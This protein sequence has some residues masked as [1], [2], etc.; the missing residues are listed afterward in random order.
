M[1][2]EASLANVGYLHGNCNVLILELYVAKIVL[3][4]QSTNHGDE[5]WPDKLD[6]T[7]VRPNKVGL[8]SPWTHGGSNQLL[9]GGK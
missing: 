1:E 3:L 7:I 2:V 5:S 9:H 6:C 8:S 4:D